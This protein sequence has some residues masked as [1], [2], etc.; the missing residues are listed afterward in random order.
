[1]QL[2]FISFNWHDRVPAFSFN[3]QCWCSRFFLEWRWSSLSKLLVVSWR[4]LCQDSSCCGERCGVL[5]LF[6]SIPSK[7]P[8][9]FV[10]VCCHESWCLQIALIFIAA[11]AIACRAWRGRLIASRPKQAQ[12]VT[13][14][15]PSCALVFFSFLTECI[16]VVYAYVYFVGPCIFWSLTCILYI[17]RRRPYLSFFDDNLVIM[18]GGCSAKWPAFDSGF[19]LLLHHLGASPCFRCLLVACCKHLLS[20]SNV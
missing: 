3:C 10:F 8:L 19:R 13:S 15:S 14:S 1:M 9:F 7:L 12:A 4:C 18:L 6:L 5:A 16:C 2:C 20:V 17:S 11:I